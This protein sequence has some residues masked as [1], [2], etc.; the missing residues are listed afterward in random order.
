MNKN[1]QRLVSG[2]TIDSDK[3]DYDTEQM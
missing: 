3:H 2:V 1:I